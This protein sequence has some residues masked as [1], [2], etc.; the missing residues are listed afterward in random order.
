MLSGQQ[1]PVLSQLKRCCPT[2]SSF[3]SQDFLSSFE[4]GARSRLANSVERAAPGSLREG[5]LARPAQTSRLPLTGRELVR[6]AVS[7]PI[8]R[9]F[10]P[11]FPVATH[12]LSGAWHPR[13]WSVTGTSATQALGAALARPAEQTVP[14]VDVVRTW[15]QASILPRDRALRDSRTHRQV[16]LRESVRLVSISLRFSRLLRRSSA[17]RPA[18]G[19]PGTWGMPS[20]AAMCPK[21]PLFPSPVTSPICARSPPRAAQHSAARK[22]RGGHRAGRTE[23]QGPLGAAGSQLAGGQDNTRSL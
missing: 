23:P 8:S 7:L 16:Q 5:G 2:K 14:M 20:G 1:H 13:G 21:S 9:D 22:Q 10:L 15:V 4:L 6:E 17:G 11:A 19:F 3:L 18:R 12:K